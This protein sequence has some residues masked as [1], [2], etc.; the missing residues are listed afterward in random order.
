MGQTH[1]ERN[2]PKKI[3]GSLQ[4][5]HISNCIALKRDFS[6]NSFFVCLFLFLNTHLLERYFGTTEGKSL[7]VLILSQP[8]TWLGRFT[9]YYLLLTNS[10]LQCKQTHVYS[11]HVCLDLTDYN[12]KA[13]S[14]LTP[15]VKVYSGSSECWIRSSVHCIE[16]YYLHF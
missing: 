12:P 15:D 14:K 11:A 8:S 9:F 3:S 16:F 13:L 7:Y 6:S 5:V 1:Y 2:F 4:W 10:K